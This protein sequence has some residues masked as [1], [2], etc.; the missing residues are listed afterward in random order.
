M[1]CNNCGG[2]T[3]NIISITSGCY[4]RFKNRK[5]VRGCYYKNIDADKIMKDIID[6][7]IELETEINKNYQENLFIAQMDTVCLTIFPGLKKEREE[8]NE[9]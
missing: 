3:D 5:L 7:M 4:G 2:L 6:K 1:K 9:M 8:K